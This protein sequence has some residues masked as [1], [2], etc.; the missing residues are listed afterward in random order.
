MLAIATLLSVLET[1]LRPEL[2]ALWH[3]R[4]QAQ[5]PATPLAAIETS[6]QNCAALEVSGRIDAT[7]A[8]LDPAFDVHVPAAELTRP[9]PGSAAL[10]GYGADGRALFSF[11]FIAAGAFKIHVALASPLA[12]ALTR[13]VLTANGQSVERTAVSGDVPSAEAVATDDTTVVLAWNARSF[14]AL[15]VA[16][17]SQGALVGYATGSGTFEQTSFRTSARR[18]TV[19]FSDGIHSFDRTLSVMGR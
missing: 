2:V 14:P 17:A 15:R 3:A 4:A 7:G 13:L 18:L 1:P 11:P 6:A 8:T 16:T 9:V 19:S 10:V 5:C 12:S